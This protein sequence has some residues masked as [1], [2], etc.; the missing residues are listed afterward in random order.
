[1]EID[2]LLM[3]CNE[4]SVIGRVLDNILPHVDIVHVV[5][6]GSTDATIE[7]AKSKGAI[8]HE[9]EWV[10]DFRV[11][12]NM[13]MS[14][15]EKEWILFMDAD[16]WCSEELLHI[17]PTLIQDNTDNHLVGGFNFWRQS[18]FD[19]DFKG[20]EYQARLLRKRCV[21]GGDIIH[22]G[23][24]A[25]GKLLDVPKEFVLHHEHTMKKQLNT[26]KHFYNIN[27]GIRVR[28]KPSEGCDY[29]SSNKKWV[30]VQL[31]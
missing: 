19:G 10:F 20:A 29:D 11:T 25:G 9:I 23:I 6:T 18:V 3:A 13:A 14:F 16:E 28:P 26:N 5:D 8:I 2:G 15:C 1:M 21:W 31:S 7:I 12:R 27:N 30:D 22:S 17:I 24:I 4:E